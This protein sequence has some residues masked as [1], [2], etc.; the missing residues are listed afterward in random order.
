[1]KTAS[2]GAD[3]QWFSHVPHCLKA[4]AFLAM[5]SKNTKEMQLLRVNK[6]KN[7]T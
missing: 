7:P 4:Q 5:K 2:P 3:S 6:S 1:M